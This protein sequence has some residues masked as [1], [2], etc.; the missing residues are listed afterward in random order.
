MSTAI[1]SAISRRTQQPQPQPQQQQPPQNRVIL[2][3]GQ[4]QP[5]RVG[6][7]MNTQQTFDLVFSRLNGLDR[8]IQEIQQTGPT[9]GV[10]N[11]VDET[12]INSIVE[13]FNSRTEILA[14]EIADLKDLL[15]KLQSFTMEVN[16]KMF[17]QT[18]QY[19]NTDLNN[20]DDGESEV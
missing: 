12:T 17:L 6:S 14:G 1:R 5:Q 16:Q 10:V 7:I 4:E 15:L 13:E 2:P 20:L 11:A 3:Q 19:D 9:G 18:E 8:T